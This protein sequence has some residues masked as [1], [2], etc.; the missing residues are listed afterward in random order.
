MEG[1]FFLF[2]HIGCF[3]KGT[4]QFKLLPEVLDALNSLFSLK[5][6]KSTKLASAH[7]GLSK[8]QAENIAI[9]ENIFSIYKKTVANIIGAF[10]PQFPGVSSGVTQSRLLYEMRMKLWPDVYAKKEKERL[11][12]QVNRT[13]DKRMS[14]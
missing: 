8:E 3:D 9:G 1:R 12:G 7:S 6:S 14:E 13:Y 11:R 10:S 5:E 2:P 4:G